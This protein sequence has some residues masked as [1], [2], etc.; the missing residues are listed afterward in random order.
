M[1]SA[2]CFIIVVVLRKPLEKQRE[3]KGDGYVHI[4][5]RMMQSERVISDAAPHVTRFSVKNVLQSA[6]FRAFI[7]FVIQP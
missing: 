4:K 3:G 6:Q 7:K 2:G 1:F 5:R